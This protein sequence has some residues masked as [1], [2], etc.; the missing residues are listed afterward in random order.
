MSEKPSPVSEEEVNR[1]DIKEVY[2][3]GQNILARHDNE[4]RW[5][6]IAKEQNDL[7]NFRDK[8]LMRSQTSVEEVMMD[9]AEKMNDAF[10]EQKMAELL[11]QIKYDTRAL[12]KSPYM[13]SRE[14]VLAA[15]E[16]NGFALGC[17][18]KELQNDR[19]VVMAAVSQIGDSIE[20]A[21][22]ELRA[23]REIAELAIAGR[24]AMTLN[25]LPTF[26]GD[27]E[28]VLRAVAT[29]GFN[30]KYAASELQNDREVVM[31]AIQGHG[32]GIRNDILAYASPELQSQLR[33]E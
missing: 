14:F 11:E 20:Y 5:K 27:R 23:D 29:N 17:A 22:E 4:A 13:K 9:D 30:L 10:D 12:E 1:P 7:R 8:L 26:R 32:Q 19:E 33:A 24:G 2:D 16:V 21:S 25:H 6:Q 18:S 15:V 31:A 28:L 3:Q